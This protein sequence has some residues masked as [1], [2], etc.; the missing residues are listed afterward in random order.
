MLGVV[1]GAR[2]LL[3]SKLDRQGVAD[4]VTEREGGSGFEITK[5]THIAQDVT[6]ET[7]K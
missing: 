2:L 4:D 3:K 7:Y 1:L 5:A 6:R